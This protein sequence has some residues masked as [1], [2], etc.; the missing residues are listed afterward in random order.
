M[1]SPNGGRN[2]REHF[3]W[4]SVLSMSGQMIGCRGMM[5][6]KRRIMLCNKVLCW[7]NA[8]CCA[9]WTASG[10]ASHYNVPLSIEPNGAFGVISS[11]TVPKAV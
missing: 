7:P 10:G 6:R 3:M 1:P 11:V 5:A 4:F 8:C 2:N 9:M